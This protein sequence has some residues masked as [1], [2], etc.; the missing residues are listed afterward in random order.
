MSC[1]LSGKLPLRRRKG[2]ISGVKMVSALQQKYFVV[3][4]KYLCADAIIFCWSDKVFLRVRNSLN[5]RQIAYINWKSSQQ[6]QDEKKPD[7]QNGR[8]LYQIKKWKLWQIFPSEKFNRMKNIFMNLK[9][10]VMSSSLG[11]WIAFHVAEINKSVKRYGKH[12]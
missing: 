7:W 12:I 6:Q 5:N 8:Y 3:L 2:S 9:S 4:T 11:N 1:F 10:R